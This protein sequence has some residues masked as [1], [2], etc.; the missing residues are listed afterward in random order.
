MN[1]FQWTELG[2]L[3]LW[4]FVLKGSFLFIGLIGVVQILRRRSA[5]T[6][7]VAWA[8]GFAGA[9]LVPFLSLVTPRIVVLPTWSIDAL[10]QWGSAFQEKSISDSARLAPSGEP[11]F[12]FGAESVF[13]SFPMN[14][15]W[16]Q[17]EL[18]SQEAAIDGKSQANTEIGKR[19]KG[20]FWAVSVFIIWLTGVLILGTRLV[21]GHC[22]I[23]SVFMRSNEQF[24]GMLVDQLNRARIDLKVRSKVGLCALEGCEVPMTYGILRPRIALPT[25]AVDWPEHKVYAVILHELAHIRRLDPVVHVITQ[26]AL[27]IHWYNPLFW[28]C[29]RGSHIDREKATDDLVLSKDVKPSFYADVLLDL[30]SQAMDSGARSPT[31]ALRMA[32]RS[33]LER[34]VMSVLTSEKDRR[35]I[36]RLGVAFAAFAGAVVAIPLTL[37]SVGV[38]G[39]DNQ[40][41]EETEGVHV[42]IP[43]GEPLDDIYTND[44]ASTSFARILGG[45]GIQAA[46]HWEKR[47]VVEPEIPDN[48]PEEFR[49]IFVDQRPEL[50]EYQVLLDEP[51][52][53][54]RVHMLKEVVSGGR[55]GH[56]EKIG[57]DSGK[58]DGMG[59]RHA[60]NVVERE[61]QGVTEMLREMYGTDPGMGQYQRSG[62]WGE[63]RRLGMFTLEIGQILWDESHFGGQAEMR[64]KESEEIIDLAKRVLAASPRSEDRFGSGWLPILADYEDWG[65]EVIGKVEAF[66]ENGEVREL[67]VFEL[68]SLR[69]SRILYEWTHGQLGERWPSRIHVQSKH[70][71]DIE[72]GRE[73]VHTLSDW[74]HF[75]ERL[76]SEL[77][78][79][80][81]IYNNSQFNTTKVNR[82][83]ELKTPDGK[84]RTV[85]IGP[86]PNR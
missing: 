62:K 41:I 14:D 51:N 16:N 26:L 40:T 49:A 84:A 76:P 64:S 68:M 15:R 56:F 30:L 47:F 74:K 82:T 22:L 1:L 48:V 71:G 58:F 86:G 67:R 72:Y 3:F 10:V 27:V 83:R 85:P 33:N 65:A 63:V 18:M 7:H 42:V 25:E 12:P 55:M 4:D 75:E 70:V 59:W 36:S 57:H 66:D 81:I 21:R 6:R 35:G 79:P 2:T 60:E 31:V 17:S 9:L 28:Y 44:L 37:L 73:T 19:K 80:E 53:V 52:D 24:Q 13:T 5:A 45:Y 23:R 29:L 34:R 78:D 77:V 20:D 46:V 32:T 43:E 69:E 39:N 11:S 61:E 50:H 8:L 38:Q 54:W